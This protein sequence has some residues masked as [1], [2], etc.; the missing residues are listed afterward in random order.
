MT[1]DELLKKFQELAANRDK[2]AGACP[3]CGR[4]PTC[5]RGGHQLAPWVMP[6]PWHYYQP[7]YQPHQVWCGTA[8]TIGYVGGGA[9]FNGSGGGGS[10]PQVSFSATGTV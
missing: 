2:H 9:G 1:N 3:S 7:Y 4:C 8:T 10:E 6:T 5:G